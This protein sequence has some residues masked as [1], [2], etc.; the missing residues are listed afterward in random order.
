M[1][2]NV[3]E[4]TRSLYGDYPYP[5]EGPERQEREDLNAPDDV[6]RVLRGGAFDFNAW[7]ARCAVRFV[8]V[9]GLRSVLDGFR[10]VVSPFFSDR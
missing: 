9:P 8:I 10:V 3:W 2:G 4:W 7:Y 1:S 5:P 6:R